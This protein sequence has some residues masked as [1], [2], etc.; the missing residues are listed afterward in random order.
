MADSSAT[1]ETVY[2]MALQLSREERAR[3]IA[4][5]APTLLEEHS[6][7][8]RQSSYGALAGLHLDVSREDIDEIRGDMLM[9][10]RG[11]SG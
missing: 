10:F 9:N 4:Q 5:I 3:L 7:H 8:P 11:E 1:Y 6:Q 2:G